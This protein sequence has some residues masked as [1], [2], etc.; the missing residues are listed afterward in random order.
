MDPRKEKRKKNDEKKRRAFIQDSTITRL[1]VSSLVTASKTLPEPVAQYLEAIAQDKV[2]EGRHED[3]DD[4]RIDIW[5]AYFL[6]WEAVVGS[7]QKLGTL[8]APFRAISC[9]VGCDIAY[10]MEI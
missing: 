8:D 5:G 10:S 1:T 2:D 9:F 3:E 4:V 7:Q 6:I